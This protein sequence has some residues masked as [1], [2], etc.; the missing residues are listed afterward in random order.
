[1]DPAL[2]EL[3][4]HRRIKTKTNTGRSTYQWPVGGLWKHYGWTRGLDAHT[5]QKKED[6]QSCAS[7]HCLQTT[8]RTNK[9]TTLSQSR[10]STRPPAI[11]N[12][13]LSS[14]LRCVSLSSV[15]LSSVQGFTHFFPYPSFAWLFTEAWAF[16]SQSSAA[17]FQK[18]QC[19]RRIEVSAPMT[20]TP[21]G[22]SSP[23]WS[24]RLLQSCDVGWGYRQGNPL[25][26]WGQLS[27]VKHWSW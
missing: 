14:F 5:D 25:A 26:T 2:R 11:S 3:R 24:P 1:M 6:G 17:A 7:I 22:F 16:T 8:G 4:S 13:G 15:T 23:S 18:A 10:L 19:T 9:K 20:L 27:A 12:S 21:L